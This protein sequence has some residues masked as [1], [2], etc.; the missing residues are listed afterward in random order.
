MENFKQKVNWLGWKVRFKAEDMRDS[1]AKK[2]HDLIY[3]EDGDTNFL[4]IIIILAIVLLLA[5]VFIAFKDKI[6]ELIDTTWTK[7]SKDFSGQKTAAPSAP[8]VPGADG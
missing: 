4:S 5:I 6:V 3:N 8:A 2:A 7:F 1:A